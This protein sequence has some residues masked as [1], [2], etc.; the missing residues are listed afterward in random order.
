MNSCNEAL[1]TFL[2]PCWTSRP[3][4]EKMGGCSGL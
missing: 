1:I 3:E 2:L 4:R